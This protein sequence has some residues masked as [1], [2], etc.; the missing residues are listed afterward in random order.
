MRLLS[1]VAC[2]D[3]YRCLRDSGEDVAPS[4]VGLTIRAMASC[5]RD[6]CVRG[7]DGASCGSSRR[8]PE[9][10]GAAVCGCCRD[11]RPPPRRPQRRRSLGA[12]PPRLLVSAPVPGP[13]PPRPSP[14][15]HWVE[16]QLPSDHN[17][18]RHPIPTLAASTVGGVPAAQRPQPHP[19]PQPAPTRVPA[20]PGRSR[21]QARSDPGRS[22]AEAPGRQRASASP[23]PRRTS[24]S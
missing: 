14:P 18:T 2:P 13:A 17:P 1:R 12:H 19:V 10:A 24:R 3:R 21:P 20:G 7:A 16:C 11:R 4:A 22:Q 6:A 8:S 15:P 23:I 9:R 5:E